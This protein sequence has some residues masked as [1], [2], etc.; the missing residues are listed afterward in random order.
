MQKWTRL[1]FVIAW[2]TV[3]V[4]SVSL[5]HSSEAFNPQPQGRW[6]LT[7]VLDSE[8]ASQGVRDY[9][10]KRKAVSYFDELV[11]LLKEDPH[12]QSL[13]QKKRLLRHC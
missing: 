13:L 11:V 12:E 4:V 2:G 5:L 8:S 1:L 10:L 9:L 7:H 3:S 6:V